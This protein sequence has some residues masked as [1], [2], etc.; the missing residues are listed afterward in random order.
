MT[1][2]NN[3]QNNSFLS[4]DSKRNT[5]KDAQR[6]NIM[7][8]KAVSNAIKSTL[9]PRGMDK[10]LVD[11]MG[12]VIV[13]NDGATI[14][15]E[16]SIEHPVGKMLVELAK[17]QDTEVGDGTTTA[18][19]IAGELV[20]RAE[21]LLD[22]NIH[23]SIIIKG[24]RMAADKANEYFKEI[25]EDIT[26]NDKDLLLSVAKTSMTGKASEYSSTLSNIVVD[27]I[28]RVAKETNQ[29][30]INKNK[31][32][33]ESKLGSNLSDTQ[34]INGMVLDKEVVHS[35]MPKSLDKPKIALINT[36]LEV[37]EPE[38]D[39]KIQITSPDQLQS[40]VD[41][42]EQTL[43]KMVEKISES[44]AN[45]VICQKGIDDLAQHYL[46]KKGILA[47]RRVKQSD[48]EN[49]ANSTNAKI[50]TRIN[51]ISSSD[52]GELEKIYQKEI[53]NDNMIFLEGAKN[54][55]Q[56]TI[57]LRASSEHVLS[58]T[59]RTLDDAIGSVISALK[60]SK[61]VAA[62]G[63]SEIS[64][65][66][67]LRDYAKTIGGR[68]QLAIDAFSDVLEYIPKIL[69]ESAGL[70]AIDTIV[71]LKNKHT[72]IKNKF[73]G[74]DVI[75]GKITDMRDKKVI[76][77]LNVKTQAISSASEVVEMILRIDD[78]IAASSSKATQSPQNQMTQGM[79]GMSG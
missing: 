50:V 45:V 49:I 76:E 16:M 17:T 78:I 9:G 66:L 2:E 34:L 35:E 22:E 67:K 37:K 8:A 6:M 70:D 33:I 65:S 56:I 48:L 58:E 20:S 79:G 60:I 59:Q 12:D 62:G 39:A 19:I 61:Y 43:K 30:I 24:Y 68:E 41:Q 23:P 74:V 42:E 36:A 25:S 44:G 51:D 63:S 52:L 72:D 15:K 55:G 21:K 28:N 46:A 71:N 27:A 32:K 57:L 13:S 69:S 1:Q 3:S 7:V 38:T 75:N 47:I 5:G 26:L 18:V 54:P 77:P 14:L 40:F 31:I 4:Q 64:V 11:E 53:A 29:K 73:I 10:M